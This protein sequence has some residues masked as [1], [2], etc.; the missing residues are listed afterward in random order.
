MHI[1]VFSIF[2]NRCAFLDKYVSLNPLL[3]ITAT[4]KDSGLNAKL[5]YS[6]ISGDNGRVFSIKSDGR[7]VVERALDR[8]SVQKYQL[9]IN[10]VDGKYAQ[11]CLSYPYLYLLPHNLCCLCKNID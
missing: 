6:I 10:V 8:E 1:I 3:Q 7:L 11:N 5:S 4:D 9:K 2:A